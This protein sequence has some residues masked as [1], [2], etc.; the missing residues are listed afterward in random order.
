MTVDTTTQYLGLRLDNPII[1]S[2]CPLTGSV[3]SLESLRQAGASAAVLPSLFEEQIEHDEMQ[4]ARMLDLW[5]LSSPESPSYFPE[6]DTY[7]TGPDSYLELISE[8]CSKLDM[9]IVAS[10]NGSTLS[11]WIRYA[12]LI[13]K[14][15]AN[16]L[17]LNIYE[18]PIAP[19]TNS[20]AVEEKYIQLLRSIREDVKIPISVKIGPYISSL[21]NFCRTLARNGVNGIVMFNR[22]MAPDIDLEALRYVPALEL[23]RP[24]ELRL[25]IRWLAI[26]RDQLDVS[27]IASGGVHTFQDVIKS[28][29]AGADAVA[30]SS[31][32]LKHGPSHIETLL[33]QSCDWLQEHEYE[34][35]GQIHGSMSLG[36]CPNPEGLQRAN[37]MQALTSFSPADGEHD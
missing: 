25:A 6:L 4:L 24:E 34:S 11:G 20:A 12:G 14:A 30:I 33:K 29:M 19:D 9:P 7:N 16:A 18:V 26:L 37:Y 15:G 2:A 21:P 31:A 35:V 32:L 3:E 23:S 17:E 27:L 5:T 28:L 8:A 36:N 13:E 1:V 10:L 22:Y